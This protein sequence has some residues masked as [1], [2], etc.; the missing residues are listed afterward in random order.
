MYYTDEEILLQE[1][2]T[3]EAN[4]IYKDALDG[5][6]KATAWKRIWGR[7]KAKMEQTYK[8]WQEQKE[9]LSEMY[10]YN[11]SQEKKALLE[12]I[13]DEN[14]ASY[15]LLTQG[16]IIP[17]AIFGIIIILVVINFYKK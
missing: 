7:S 10:T 3:D 6:E 9:I 2:K 4:Q 17:V 13:N 15:N 8:Y 11:D 1:E 12:S 16:S 14:T 5:W